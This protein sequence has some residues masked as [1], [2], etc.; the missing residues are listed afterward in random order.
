VG[1]PNLRDAEWLYGGDSQ[2]IL[3]SILDGRQGVMPAWGSALG[4]DGANEAAAYVLSLSG[5]DAPKEWVA[6]GKPRYEAMCVACH[7]PDGRGNP[8]LGAPSLVDATWLYGGDFASIAT[9]IRNGRN[10]AMP[11]W[12][13]RLGEDRVRTIAAWLMS[14]RAPAPTQTGE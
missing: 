3:A 9:S 7:G 1:A 11:A 13:Q 6:A 14:Q 12:R 10:G 8:S 4:Y 2:S 5:T